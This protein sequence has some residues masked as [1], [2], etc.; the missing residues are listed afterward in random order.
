MHEPC[1]RV[2]ELLMCAAHLVVGFPGT[3]FSSPPTPT[4]SGG[5]SIVSPVVVVGTP[6]VHPASLPKPFLG[7]ES[8]VL[9]SVVL[10]S[11]GLAS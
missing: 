1:A 9:A 7:S 6:L 5:V 11:A 10:V 8:M 2:P 4:S 3:T